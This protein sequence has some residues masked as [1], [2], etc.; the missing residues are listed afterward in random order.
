MFVLVAFIVLSVINTGA[1]LDQRCWV[2]ALEVGR[3]M[4]CCIWLQLAHPG[5]IVTYAFMMLI[6]LIALFYKSARTFYLNQLYF[7]H[8]IGSPSNSHPSK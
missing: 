6:A 3:L 2:F 8:L 7:R 4:L 5:F 1:M